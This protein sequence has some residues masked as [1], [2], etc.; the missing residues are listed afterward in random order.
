VT[1]D[2]AGRH[3]RV[4]DSVLLNG[5]VGSGKSTVAAALGDLARRHG[6]ANAVID[7]DELRRAWPAPDDDP[8]HLELLLANLTAVVA[9]DRR[10]G[11]DRFIVAGVIED[12]ADVARYRQALQSD[13]A[14]V[15]RLDVDDATLRHRLHSR[16]EGRPE[17]L[18][19]HLHRVGEL[20]AILDGAGVDD[21]VLDAAGV[22]AEELAER[23]WAAAGW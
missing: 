18:G 20:A 16:H 11:I 1:A 10:A 2:T 12:R 19:W 17:E 22:S 13:G 4:I 15:V 21:L 7:L 8:F 6:V 5:T 9:N 3:D 14:L 23:V